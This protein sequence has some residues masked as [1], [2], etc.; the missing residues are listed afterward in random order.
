M[1]IRAKCVNKDCSEYGVTKSVLM[2][3]YAG[4]GAPNERIICRTCQHL[5]RTTRAVSMADKGIKGKRIVG[6]GIKTG[7]IRYGKKPAGK[8]TSEKTSGNRKK[9]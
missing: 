4:Q 8:K 3:T 6:T 5:M 9:I 1:N 2:E 7:T